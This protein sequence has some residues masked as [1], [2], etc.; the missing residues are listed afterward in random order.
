MATH[1]I[2]SRNAEC[3]DLIKRIIDNFKITPI[4]IN[5][6]TKLIIFD[7]QTSMTDLFP[8]GCNR[9]GPNPLIDYVVYT[10]QSIR[11]ILKRRCGLTLSDC[12]DYINI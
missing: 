6:E 1:V 7:N 4:Q 9:Y 8:C 5:E 11:I 10:T 12:Y 3:G 2:K